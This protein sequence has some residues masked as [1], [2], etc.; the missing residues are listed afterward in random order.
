M[1]RLLGLFLLFWMG[2]VANGS[3]T[4]LINFIEDVIDA[5]KLDKP[6]IVYDR[7]EEIP[8]I[9]YTRPRVLCL[10]S[11]HSVIKS[12]GSSN[13]PKTKSKESST[14]QA[15][16][17][18]K[19]EQKLL[20]KEDYFNSMNLALVYKD[21]LNTLLG[22]HDRGEC[23]FNTMFISL[24]TISCHGDSECQLQHQLNGPGSHRLHD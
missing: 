18:K 11:Q 3:E 21:M 8:K 4:N 13:E 14:E 19:G 23:L 17:V 24:N 1:V 9:C 10:P 16:Y 12:D 5:Y 6:T 20:N 7:N 22:S 15:T 2:L